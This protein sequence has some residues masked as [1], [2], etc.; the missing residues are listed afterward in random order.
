MRQ[1]CA[2]SL[3]A[4]LNA[5]VMIHS[6][7][8]ARFA[9]RG[10]ERAVAIRTVLRSNGRERSVRGTNLARHRLEAVPPHPLHLEGTAVQRIIYALLLLLIF[11]L[12]FMQPAI[13]IL[14]FFA[15][16][17]DFIFLALAALWSVLVIAR[18]ARITWD[19]AYL[20]IGIYLAAMLISVPGSQ[21]V[22][23]SLVKLLTQLYL[24]SLP[25][26]VCSL[27][28]GEAQLRAAV[29]SWLAGSALVGAIA[30]VGLVLFV[31]DPGS[32]LLG[33]LSSV[34]GT[35]PPGNY[36]RL[37]LTFMNPNMICDYLTVS[38]MLLLAARQAKWLGRSSSVVLLALVLIASASTISPGLGGIA[39]GI[40]LWGWLFLKHR[41]LARLFLL[42]GAGAAILFVFAIMITP[43]LHPTA[44]YLIHLPLL[45]VTVAPSGRLMIWTDAARNF[46]AHPL[47]G[48]GI[49]VDPVHVHYL[50]PSGMFETSTDAH[51][52]FLSL[53]VQCGI[54]G[55]AA[56]LLLLRQMAIR[57]FPLR[58]DA[59]PV[60]IVRM[61]I[62]L[63]LLIALAYEGLGGS[64]EDSRHLWVAFGLLL[65]SDRLSR[66]LGA[67][68]G[69]AE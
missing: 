56:F 49:G 31:V 26:I 6:T 20:F 36:P 65:A 61:G 60:T 66:P 8:P 15:V 48:R 3:E 28:R 63:G 13:P 35:L 32:A 37:Q 5:P 42:A 9:V 30:I 14:G 22:R 54:I 46:L 52:A 41:T 11:S 16:P 64:F 33:F 39:L 12:A 24:A 58:A 57:T 19:P 59:E 47:T 55:L 7:L 29:A 67:S 68:S 27:V 43:I 17:T 45:D 34:K 50:D 53:A 10:L 23:T 21:S 1:M 44:P 4:R 62:G 2:D 51:D 25:V 38:L 40:G 69:G 18:R